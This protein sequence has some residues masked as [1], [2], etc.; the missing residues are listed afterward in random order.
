MKIDVKKYLKTKNINSFNFDSSNG[1]F[2][3]TDVVQK[4]IIFDVEKL[5]KRLDREILNEVV[6]KEYK[7]SDWDNLVKYLKSCGVNPKKFATF[8]TVEKTV[9]QS[10]MNELSKL[11]EITPEDI[12]GCYEVKENEG[13]IKISEIENAKH[14]E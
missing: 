4:K 6:E 1:S 12:E 14:E 2:K 5:E 13:Y 8:L 7:I 10:K 9:N 3:V 11:G